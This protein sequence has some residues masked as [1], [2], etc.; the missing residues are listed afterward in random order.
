MG[1]FSYS[2]VLE[3]VVERAGVTTQSTAS[4]SLVDQFQLTLARSDLPVIA[5]A[6]PAWREVNLMRIQQL[7]DW[8]LQSRENSELRLQAEQMSPC[9]WVKAPGSAFWPV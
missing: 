5:Q 2:E 3:S 6:I 8:V 4:D 1:G 7:K 9:R